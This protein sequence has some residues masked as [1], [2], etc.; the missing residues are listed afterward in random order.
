MKLL[1]D[2]NLSPRLSLLLADIFA[3]SIHVREVGLR[4]ADDLAIWQYAKLTDMQSFRKTQTFN[5]EVCSRAH[6]RNLSG[7]VLVTVLQGGLKVC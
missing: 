7:Y 1:F 4:D 6:H 3:E 2:Q 5:S